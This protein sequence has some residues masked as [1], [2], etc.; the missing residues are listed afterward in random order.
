M[1]VPCDLFD[2]FSHLSTLYLVFDMMT[3]LGM[4]LPLRVQQEKTVT[5]V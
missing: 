5:G 3:Y 4:A 1:P 2:A